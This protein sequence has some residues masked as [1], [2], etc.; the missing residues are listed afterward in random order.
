MKN[1]VVIGALALC[2]IS[3]A[4]LAA[5]VITPE[6]KNVVCEE[7]FHYYSITPSQQQF[8]RCLTGQFVPCGTGRVTR[9]RINY[10]N[11]ILPEGA[12]CMVELNLN[13]L[14][15]SNSACGE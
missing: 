8:R 1:F 10:T 4:T 11:G 13:S 9:T 2:S 7:I 5:P 12:A 15:V 6:I 14:K 3:V